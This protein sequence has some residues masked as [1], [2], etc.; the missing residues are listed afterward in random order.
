MLDK[1]LYLIFNLLKTKS[2]SLLLLLLLL[3]LQDVHVLRSSSMPLLR[4]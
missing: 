3:L 2:L 1:Y 4:N